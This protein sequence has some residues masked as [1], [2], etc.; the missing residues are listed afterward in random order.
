MLIAVVLKSHE[1]YNEIQKVC[2]FL[3]NGSNPHKLYFKIFK[4][5]RSKC[6]GFGF[7]KKKKKERKKGKHAG[8]AYLGLKPGC[9]QTFEKLMLRYQFIALPLVKNLFLFF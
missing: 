1:I 2:S 4:E 7:K 8:S 6:S 3:T 5:T 9:I